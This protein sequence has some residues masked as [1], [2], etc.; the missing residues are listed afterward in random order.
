MLL[1][2][3]ERSGSICALKYP[4][5]KDAVFFLIFS[6]I[7]THHPAFSPTNC[8]ALGNQSTHAIS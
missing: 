5:K 1:N 2:A 8:I 4:A 7:R 6:F 3:P